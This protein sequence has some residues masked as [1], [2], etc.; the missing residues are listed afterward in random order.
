MQNAM[1]WNIV[2]SSVC[3]SHRSKFLTIFIYCKC[4]EGDIQL[5]STSL[6]RVLPWHIGGSPTTICEL[7]RMIAI[8]FRH[9]TNWHVIVRC[10]VIVIGINASIPILARKSNTISVIMQ[11]IK[12]LMYM[13][14]LNFKRCLMVLKWSES[15]TSYNMLIQ[16]QNCMLRPTWSSL[17]RVVIRKKL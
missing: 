6:K 17:W 8:K 2:F 13:Y 4:R 14:L 10:R 9:A 11:R 3:H 16:T 1:I 15:C 7:I 5:Q 12:D